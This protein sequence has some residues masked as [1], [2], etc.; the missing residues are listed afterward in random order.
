MGIPDPL[1]LSPEIRVQVK[2]QQLQPDVE[3]WAGSKLGKQY[4]KTVHCHIAYFT[5]M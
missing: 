3:Q 2:K 1:N 4:I 5:S